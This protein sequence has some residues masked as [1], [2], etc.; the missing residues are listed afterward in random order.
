[1]SLPASRVQIDQLLAHR[2]WV[3]RVA[4]AMVRDENDADDLEQ[5]LWLDALQNPPRSGRSLRGWLFTALRR[6]SANA[7]HAE[8]CRA[9]REESTARAEALPSAEELVAKTDAHKRVVNAVMDLAEPYRSTVLYRFFE[10]LSPMAIAERQGVPVETV[11]TRLKRALAQVRQRFDTE[12]EGDRERWCLALLPL[13]RRSLNKSAARGTAAATAGAVIMSVK[14][15]VVVA[16]VTVAVVAASL[17]LWSS[18][19]EHPEIAGT[20]PVAAAPVMH[21]VQGER[22]AGQRTSPVRRASQDAEASP[23][24]AAGGEVAAP[25]PRR[26]ARCSDDH[27]AGLRPGLQRDLSGTAR[28]H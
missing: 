11:R 21:T 27:R 15:K 26:G 2:E 23:Q 25:P 14:A 12:N 16:L 13:L 1:M 22:P 24:A 9:R 7:R 5:G 3:R 18:R 4:R 28:T 17:L 19:S 20:P 8:D 10:D 6:D